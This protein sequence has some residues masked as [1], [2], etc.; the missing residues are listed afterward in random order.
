[1]RKR[2]T[3]AARVAQLGDR[4]GELLESRG[5]GD[6][7]FS[8]Y[9]DDPVGFI[10]DVLGETNPGP[11]SAQEDVARAVRDEPLVAVRGCHSSGKDWL[12]ARLALWWVYAKGGF[13]L[14][15]GPTERQVREILMKETSV[16]FHGSK[17]LAG[18]LFTMALRIPGDEKRGILSFV[19]SDASRMTGFHAPRVLA[20]ITEA[21][22][23]PAFAWEALLNC[24]TGDEDRIL[25]VGNPLEPT[26]QFYQVSQPG[27]WRGI[28]ISAE[29]HPNVVT[30]ER[31][32]PGGP[33]RVWR[34]R[35]AKE[36]GRD[37]N[38]YLSRVLAEFPTEGEESLF[39]REWLESAADQWD[40]YHHPDRFVGE[41]LKAAAAEAEPLISVDVARYGPDA[42]CLA[43]R[44]GPVITRIV[45]WHGRSLTDSVR[46]IEEEAREEGLRRQQMPRPK[47]EYQEAYGVIVVDAVGLGAGVVDQ[48]KDRGWRVGAYN[49]GQFLTSGE[50]GRF[51]NERAKSHWIL[52][53]KLE[54]GEIALPRMKELFDEL[55]AVNWRPTSDG[56][57]QIEEK[58]KMKG[59]LGRSPDHSDAVV[60]AFSGLGSSR[61]KVLDWFRL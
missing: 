58:T 54:A 5:G 8:M 39:N 60:M 56:K 24:A 53:R 37:S 35:I 41:E 47:W 61:F 11:W 20:I 27:R 6:A 25:A 13:A 44:R 48:L 42:T 40:A 17:G 31:V 30:G 9:A 3:V 34:D 7:D 49:G 36:Y 16:A 14:M 22:G 45:K 21:Q 26:G 50:R 29:E 51:L 55:M 2:D 23:V 1:V 19:S 4:M 57:V 18:D 43:V 52:R 32:V 28:R 59:R 10:R 33:T 38:T 12:S 15:T 46:R